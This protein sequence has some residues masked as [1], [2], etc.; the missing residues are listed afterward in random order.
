METALVAEL[1]KRENGLLDAITSAQH[2]VVLRFVPSP[3]GMYAFLM[4]GLC[5]RLKCRHFLKGCA[6]HCGQEGC[7]TSFA[8]NMAKRMEGHTITRFFSESC[9]VLVVSLMKGKTTIARTV[10]E[11]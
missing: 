2:I 1:R 11:I 10:I 3:I 8:Q 7:D 6:K 9:H 5:P 4:M